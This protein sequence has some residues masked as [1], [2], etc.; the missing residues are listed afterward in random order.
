MKGKKVNSS[1]H[2]TNKT[3]RGMFVCLERR[4]KSQQIAQVAQMTENQNNVRKAK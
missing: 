1:N 2:W 4:T 3:H